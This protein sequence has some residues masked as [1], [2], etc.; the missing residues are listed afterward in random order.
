MRMTVK[1]LNCAIVL[2]TIVINY[3]CYRSWLLK[4]TAETVE[5]SDAK[6]PPNRIIQVTQVCLAYLRSKT[7]LQQLKLI[8]RKDGPCFSLFTVSPQWADGDRSW[9][10][11]FLNLTGLRCHFKRL[12]SLQFSIQKQLLLNANCQSDNQVSFTVDEL[13]E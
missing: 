9:K 2:I 11:I 12:N 5:Y 1:L 8:V 7:I 6:L 13:F 10:I 4:I 3:D